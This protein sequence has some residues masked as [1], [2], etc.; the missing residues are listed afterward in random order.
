MELPSTVAKA[1]AFLAA[2]RKTCNITESARAAGVGSRQHYRWLE[3]YPK[4]KAAF[5]C[6]QV[7]AADYLESVAIERAS[8]GWEEPVFYQGAECGRV[9]RF[10][11]GL[12]QFLLRGA[13]PEKY[14]QSTELT[15][16][17]GGPIQAKLEVVFVSGPKAEAP[18]E[19][20]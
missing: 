2:Y 14:K 3:K 16:A 1:R 15:G 4:Y 18:A 20:A 17:G 12:M 5:E 7:I 19:K 8:I 11:G 10:D 9:R 6:A 13:K